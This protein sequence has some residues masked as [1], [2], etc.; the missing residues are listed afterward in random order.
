MCALTFLLL[1]STCAAPGLRD[2]Q[3]ETVKPSKPAALKPALTQSPSVPPAPEAP[4]STEDEARFAGPLA[5]FQRSLARTREAA[6]KTR[7]LFFG[8]SHVAADYMTGR[9]R[10]RL[11]AEYGDAGPGFILAG[12]PWRSF[13]HDR[14]ELVSVRGL[15]STYIRKRPESEFVKLG[16]AG[17]MT[18]PA[19]SEDP[20]VPPEAPLLRFRVKPATTPTGRKSQAELFYLQKPSN[21]TLR[22]SLDSKPVSQLATRAEL[23]SPGYFAF[24][25]PD[26]S[27]HEI[28]L[29]A[30]P[31]ESF[32]LF[33]MVV[34]REGAGVVL[35]TLGIPGARARAQLYWEPSLLRE[36]M[37]KRAPA[38]WVLAFGTNESTDVTQPIADYKGHLEKV[39]TQMQGALPDASCLLVG[40]TD[41]PEKIKQGEYRARERTAQINALQKSAAQ[42]FGCAFFDVIES[43]GGPLSMLSW[44]RAEP[45][46]GAKDLI[47]LTRPG[48]VLLGDR[49][50]DLLL[51]QPTPEPEKHAEA[52]SR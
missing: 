23:E 25:L 46:L 48:Y 7:I 17:V 42:R 30:E 14:I 50:A 16:L 33:G 36:H 31:T 39:L 15:H 44:A 19:L 20:E 2:A 10:E 34:E 18:I 21:G 40:P 1:L 49:I 29:S 5:A 22:I 38:L 8:D 9:I 6:D 3:A 47:H 11:Q 35:D 26:D 13:R 24:E 12:R 43:M 51:A 52:Q 32:N 27:V 4:P 41:F 37:Q 45:P 28:S